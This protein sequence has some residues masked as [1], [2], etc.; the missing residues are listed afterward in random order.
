MAVQ[1]GRT[2]NKYITL[3]VD[4][5]GGTLRTIVGTESIGG[6]GVDYDSVDV[7]AL[8]DAINNVLQG[9]GTVVIPLTGQFDNTA[10]TGFHVVFSAVN[11]LNIP[12]S[13]DIQ[14]GVRHAWETGEQQFGITSSATSGALV[15]NYKVSGDLKC[16]CEL[17]M[18]G[19]TAPAWGTAAET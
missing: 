13:F 9:R 12:L 17:V 10:D 7:T 11:G 15:R 18:Y 3:K 19:A 8:E 2:V 4:D 14:F 6:V 5:S 1:T 16:S